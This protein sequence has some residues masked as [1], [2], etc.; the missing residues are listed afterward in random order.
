[1]EELWGKGQLSARLSNVR[2]PHQRSLPKLFFTI[3]EEETGCN[4]ISSP[5]IGSKEYSF[6]ALPGYQNLYKEK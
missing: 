5:T 4:G 2:S 3:S 1:M 6:K